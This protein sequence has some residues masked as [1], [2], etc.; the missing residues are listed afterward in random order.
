MMPGHLHPDHLPPVYADEA[1]AI[2]AGLGNGDFFFT[3]GST[4]LNVVL[5][6]V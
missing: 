2:A 4:V 3:T 6:D 5:N 1:A